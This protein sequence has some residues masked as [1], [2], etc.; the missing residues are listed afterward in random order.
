VASLPSP[1]FNSVDIGP[2]TLTLYGLMIGLG[3]IAAA[4]LAR[5][6]SYAR[7][8][9]P[10]TPIEMLGWLV[11]PGIIGARIYHLV[12]DWV[13]FSRWHQVWEGGLGV[14]GAILGGVL[15]GM[16][17]VRRKGLSQNKVFDAFVPGVPLAQAIGRLGNWWNQ[18]LYGEPTDLPWGL[19]IDADHRVPGFAEFETFHPT[20]LYELLWNLG[21]VGLLIWVDRKGVLKPGRLIWV[22][23]GGYAIGRL[24]IEALRIDNATKVAGVRVNIWTMGI[25]LLISLFMLSRSRAESAPIQAMVSDGKA[26]D[27]DDGETEIERTDEEE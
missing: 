13:P 26:A 23:A 17:Y 14:P 7:G 2:F 6:R 5:P 19:E 24:W 16:F 21:L 25:L 8:M 10:D 11:I 18:E 4:L 27:G 9:H 15:G 12:T 22:Y 20:F 3:I 1:S